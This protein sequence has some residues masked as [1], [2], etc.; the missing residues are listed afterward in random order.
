M[1]VG[2]DADKADADKAVDRKTERG[3]LKLIIHEALS[4]M[5][6]RATGVADVEPYDFLI[7]I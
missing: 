2:G 6:T 7:P 5:M 4:T 1:L 3:K